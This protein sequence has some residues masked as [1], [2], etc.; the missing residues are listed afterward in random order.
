MALFAFIPN[1]LAQDYP[2]RY[3][4]IVSP[5]PPGGPSDTTARLIAGPMARALNQQIVVEDVT[6][7]PYVLKHG[8]CLDGGGACPPACFL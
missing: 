5:F 8:V 1:A 3:I 6:W 2:N 7:A 4:T